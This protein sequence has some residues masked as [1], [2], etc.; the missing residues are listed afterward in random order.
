MLPGLIRGI[1]VDRRTFQI[2]TPLTGPALQQVTLL[3]RGGGLETPVAF[4]AQQG[5]DDAPYLSTAAADG[6]GLQRRRQQ[7]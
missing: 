2:L 1:D 4:F 3:L 6:V 5:L 7:K